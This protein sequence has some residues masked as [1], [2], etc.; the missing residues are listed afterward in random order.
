MILTMLQLKELRH[1]LHAA[2]QDAID[3]NGGP[4]FCSESH[5]DAN[6]EKFKLVAKPKA[7]EHVLKKHG[8][9]TCKIGD[10]LHVKVPL[11]VHGTDHLGIDPETGKIVCT[12]CQKD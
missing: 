10:T 11:G 3:K 6:G 7:R 8:H 9:E 5:T 1:K 12:L 2:K 4:F